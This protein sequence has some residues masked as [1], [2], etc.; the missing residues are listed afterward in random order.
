M[1]GTATTVPIEEVTI[2]LLLAHMCVRPQVFSAAKEHLLPEHFNGPGEIAYRLIARALYQYEEQ[3]KQLPNDESLGTFALA[4]LPEEAIATDEDYKK[5]QSFVDWLRTSQYAAGTLHDDPFALDILKALLVERKVKDD[6][7]Q[8]MSGF[9][10]TGATVLPAIIRAASKS[11]EEIESINR[12]ASDRNFPEEGIVK[13]AEP[14]I[15]MGVQILDD[16]MQGGCRITD[17]N[18]FLGPTGGGKTTLCMQLICSYAKTQWLKE[19]KGEGRGKLSVFISYEADKEEMLIR[20]ICFAA[21]I[22][23]TRL[24]KMRDWNRELARDRMPYE[25]QADGEH[26]Q[27][28]YERYKFAYKWLNE[29]TYFADFTGRRD[30]DNPPRG[31]GGINEIRSELLVRQDSFDRALGVTASDWAGVAVQRNLMKEN[32]EV[33]SNLT[34]ALGQYVDEFKGKIAHEFQAPCWISHQLK[35][36]ANNRAPTANLTHADAQW[37]SVFAQ[38]ADFNFI[39]GNEDRSTHTCQFKASKTRRGREGS[40]TICYINGEFGELLPCD[41][42][43]AVVKGQ[44]VKASEAGS[45]GYHDG[46]SVNGHHPDINEI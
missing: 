42:H 32:K 2:E 3:Y 28:E 9:A 4:K 22:Q 13:S 37:C 31:S 29:F 1:E 26:F 45:L 25:H 6:L 36:Q 24:E 33:A 21:R 35:G 27:C 8:S 14:V 40:P 17:V 19:K 12:V 39:I 30:G 43:Y 38:H 46:H 16:R 20:A 7:M 34:M 18:T 41:R 11:M 23:R 15:P 10:A 5:V 44:I